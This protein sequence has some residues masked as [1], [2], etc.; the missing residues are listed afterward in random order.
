VPAILEN[1]PCAYK[2][3]LIQQDNATP[4]ITPAE[5][6]VL[7]LEKKV[8]LQNRHGGGLDWDLRLYFQPANSPDTDLNNLAG[9]FVSIQALQ[10]QHLS[11]NIGELTARV[12][13]LYQTYPYAKLN[14]V[15]LT[16]QTCMNQIMEAHGSND[17]QLAH[18]N[19]AQLERLGS[20]PQSIEHQNDGCGTPMRTVQVT[21]RNK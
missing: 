10:F 18:I 14:N 19:K 12:L 2:H 6:R 11:G 8:E 4:H 17:Y 13:Q 9:F 21:M 15:F 1:W 7:W 3:V 16:L 5:F 20:L